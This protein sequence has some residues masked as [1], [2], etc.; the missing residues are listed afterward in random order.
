MAQKLTLAISTAAGENSTFTYVRLEWRRLPFV[1]R[2]GVFNV[3]MPVDQKAGFVRIA[4]D[5]AEHERVK[6]GARDSR[7]DGTERTETLDKQMGALVERGV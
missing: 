4:A 5:A 6:V 2:P 1:Q 3:E 7:I